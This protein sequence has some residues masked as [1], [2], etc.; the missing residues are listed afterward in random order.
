MLVSSLVLTLAVYAAGVLRVWRRAGIGCGVRRRDV[1][2]FAGA[3]LALV[4]ALST[5]MDEWAEHWLAAHMVQHELLMVVAAPLLALATPIVAFLWALPA[6]WR[7]VAAAMVHHRAPATVWRL[8]TSPALAFFLYGA[9]LW[10]WHLPVMY[11]FALE[12]EA[13]HILQHLCF[14]GTATL[15]WWGVAHGRHG[16]LG[17]GAA[18]VYVF[19]TTMHGGLLGALLTIAPGVWYASYLRP[20]AHGLTPLEDQQ[21]AGLFMWVPASF[22]FVAAGLMLFAAWLR[23]SD[24]GTR[25]LPQGTPPAPSTQSR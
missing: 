23:H 7:P 18:V 1:A 15:F 4:A 24:R 16:R 22:A 19:A 2:A 3:M 8:I 20:H 9:A 11:E 14:F 21:L 13:A 6:G 12:H 17:Y 10:A 5:P 25:Y